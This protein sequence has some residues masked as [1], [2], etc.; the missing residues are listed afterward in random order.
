MFSNISIRKIDDNLNLYPINESLYFN[1]DGDS[2][3]LYISIKD[4]VKKQCL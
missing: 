2:I 1:K 4:L 3:P